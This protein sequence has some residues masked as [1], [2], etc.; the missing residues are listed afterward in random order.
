M[1]PSFSSPGPPGEVSRAA[2][3]RSASGGTEGVFSCPS[4]RPRREVDSAQPRSEGSCTNSPTHRPISIFKSPLRHA[5]DAVPPPRALAGRNNL[6]NPISPSASSAF[7]PPLL[8]P[9]EPFAIFAFN[10]SSSSP[11]ASGQSLTPSSPRH[12]TTTSRTTIPTHHRRRNH[13]VP[14]ID[15]L[16][17]SRPSADGVNEA[18]KEE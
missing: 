15:P 7:T 18:S 11:M 1:G 3:R 12:P 16:G 9:F 17:Q 5:V 4:P 10:P 6:F 14:C 13:R 8:L 2:R